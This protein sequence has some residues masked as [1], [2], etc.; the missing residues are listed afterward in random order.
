M[1]PALLVCCVSQVAGALGLWGYVERQSFDQ[2][3]EDE[4]WFVNAFLGFLKSSSCR[5]WPILDY[6]SHVF[7]NL[8]LNLQSLQYRFLIDV[9]ILAKLSRRILPLCLQS[10]LVWIYDLQQSQ[11]I[12]RWIHYL[13][14]LLHNLLFII[15]GIVENVLDRQ[16]GNYWTYLKSNAP[17]LWL[18]GCDEELWVEWLCWEDGHFSACGCELCGW[19]VDGAQLDQGWEGGEE[20]LLIRFVNEIHLAHVVDSHR[21]QVEDDSA[22]VASENLRYGVLV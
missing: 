20:A 17:I 7:R 14:P 2:A 13:L 3:F 1:D 22:E 21:F 15:M 5:M 11:M 19:G 9:V 18:K 16:H 12:A 8:L 10:I 6:L 4:I